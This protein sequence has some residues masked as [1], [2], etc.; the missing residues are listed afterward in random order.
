MKILDVQHMEDCFD[1]STTVA[2]CFDETWTKESIFRLKNMGKLE[3]FP[4][5]PRPFFR[6]TGAGGL[7]IKGVQGENSC[8]VIFPNQGREALRQQFEDLFES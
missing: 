7:Q 1:G 3:Y 6:L 5:F 8:R 4:D 2:Y